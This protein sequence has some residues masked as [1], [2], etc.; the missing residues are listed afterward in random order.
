LESAYRINSFVTLAQ[1]FEWANSLQVGA[2]RS[3]FH[4]CESWSWMLCS[5]AFQGLKRGLQGLSNFCSR[6]WSSWASLALNKQLRNRS[7]RCW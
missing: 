4:M 7:W 2:N 5:Q 6:I 3:F 1:R